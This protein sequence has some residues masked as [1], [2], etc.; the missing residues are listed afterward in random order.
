MKIY[1]PTLPFSLALSFAILTLFAVAFSTPVQAD[2]NDLSQRLKNCKL[3][4]SMIT[5]A[6]CYDNVVIDFDIANFNRVDVGQG[7][8]KWKITSEESPVTGHQ[9]Y[10]ATLISDDYVRNAAGKFNRP[11]LVLRC[12]GK[13]MEGYIIWDDVLG[14]K[15]VVINLR[16]GEGET[17]A[18]RWALS[19]DKQA[20]FIPDTANFTKKLVGQARFTI[21]AWSTSSDPLVTTFDLR[22]SDVALK[23]LIA[24][25]GL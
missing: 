19:A 13:K 25:C 22:G 6:Q 15:E 2:Q 10:F 23:P 24:A 20:A 12:T 18:G 17:E 11:S 7:S 1:Q 5:R 4:T 3:I 8:G 14:E 16:I 9:D 21:K